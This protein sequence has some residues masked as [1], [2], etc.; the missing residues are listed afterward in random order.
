VQ[1]HDDELA[2]VERLLALCEVQSVRSGVPLPL[3]AHR[4]GE[5]V[6]FALLSRH[7]TGVRLDLFAHVDDGAPTRTIIL[8]PARNKTGDIWHVWLEGIAPGQLYGYRVAGPY[9][10]AE[11]HRFNPNK[12]LVDPYA[13]AIA[14]VPGR[15]FSAAA[16]STDVAPSE[17]DDAAVAPKC[18]VTH[19]DFDWRGDQPLHRPWTSTVLYELHVRGA[20]VHPSANVQF[21]GTYRGLVEKIPYFKDLGITAVELMPVLEFNEHECSKID[22]RTGERLR[23]YWGYDPVGLF[24]PKAS[25]A[26]ARAHGAA[27]LEL[28]EMVRA[29][30]EAGLEVILDLV[31]N[32]TVEGNELGPTLGLRGIDNALYYWLADDPSRYRDFTGTGHTIRAS[33]PIVRDLILDVLRYWVIEAHIDGFRIDLASVLGRD[34]R[35]QVVADPPLLERIAED[36]IL[37]DTKLIA[38][39]WD[40]AGA[41]QVGS[42]SAPRWAEWNGRFRDDV[43]RF[44][45]GDPG[46]IGALASRITGSS[47]LYQGSGKGPEC[48][49][50]FVTCH[51]GFTLDDLVSYARKHN[52]RNGEGGRDGSDDNLSSN[53][54]VEGPSDDPA[55]EALRTRQIKNFLLTLAVSRGVPMILAGDEFRRTQG[56]N[57]NAYCQDNETSWIDWSLA[58]RHD[59]VRRFLRAVLAL[60][61]TYPVLRRQEFYTGDDVTWFSPDG[62][63][64][65]WDDPTAR[66]VG[67]LLRDAKG[68]ELCLLFNAAP[69][70]CS[71]VLPSGRWRAAVDTSQPIDR[72]QV[73]TTAS[74]HLAARTSAVLVGV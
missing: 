67:C 22:P 56:G 25:Y 57:N 19:D 52:E 33:H 74:Y 65:R 28:K 55:I 15:D 70:A 21:P 18:V 46:M 69:D 3:G 48:S 37:H 60:R 5:G 42:F 51:D 29:F 30:H 14:L 41:Y 72:T 1:E 34:S 64:P 32:H 59:E 12:L 73:V 2:A 44:W 49:I 16:G 35:G 45:R 58:S 66:R 61:R 39:A 53:H 6:N 36:P 26:S 54:G 31:L 27:L 11:G 17:A 24:A 62:T 13:T 20:T 4:R 7:A 10:P 71:F 40:V 50:N 63:P 8:D 47:D 9:A 68:P 23:N 38:E 43:R